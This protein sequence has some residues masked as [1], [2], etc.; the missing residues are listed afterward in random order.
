M[1]IRGV[2][3]EAH[4][5]TQPLDGGSGDE[6]RPF[7]RV[8]WLLGLLCPGEGRQKT[9]SAVDAPETCAHHQERPRTPCDLRL[10]R[11][12]RTLAE[13]ARL[14]VAEDAGQRDVAVHKIRIDASENRQAR[15]HVGKRVAGDAEQRQCFG[16]PIACLDVEEERAR[17]VGLVGRVAPGEVSQKP[18][19]DG[20]EDDLALRCPIAQ[21]ADILQQ[22]F[23]FGRREVRIDRQAGSSTKPLCCRMPSERLASLRGPTILPHDGGVER[24]PGRTIPHD[25]RLALIAQADRQERSARSR[26]PGKHLLDHGARGREENLRILLDPPG[27]RRAQGQFA[28]GGIDRHGTRVEQNKPN[29]R[30]ADV[31]RAQRR[32]GSV[33]RVRCSQAANPLRSPCHTA[34][35]AR[36]GRARV[37]GLQR[38]R[39]TG[40]YGP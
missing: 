38:I 4:G 8:S 10:S 5:I 39:R 3:Q 28:I 7:E 17:R 23:D 35:L 13:E 14:L 25:D 2:G 9:V 40:A 20:P 12:N 36:M 37:Q 6:D 1:R 29:A 19:I 11:G 22:P 30:R 18:C 33:L 31:D 21:A 32:M 15:R 34:S 27:A 26:V 24:A 16:I